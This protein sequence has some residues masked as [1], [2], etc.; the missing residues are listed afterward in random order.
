MFYV[1]MSQVF[2]K[3]S[4][5][6]YSSAVMDLLVCS[7]CANIFT[8]IWPCSTPRLSPSCRRLRVLPRARATI[9]NCL[10]VSWQPRKDSR[11]RRWDSRACWTSWMSVCTSAS[12]WMRI[13]PVI[14]CYR[15]WGTPEKQERRI[16]PLFSH[17]PLLSSGN[18]D[19]RLK[20][21]D[22]LSST[23]PTWINLSNWLKRV[24]HWV[25]YNKSFIRFVKKRMKHRFPRKHAAAG[26]LPFPKRS[27]IEALVHCNLLL[28]AVHQQPLV[29][30][31]HTDQH[32]QGHHIQQ[33]DHRE[34]HTHSWTWLEHV[35]EEHGANRHKA[36]ISGQWK[37]YRSGV[38]ID[39]HCNVKDRPW[40]ITT[41]ISLV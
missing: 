8:R 22:R 39:D 26:S 29:E 27:Y 34:Q 16:S 17:A 32:A 37:R 19:N 4:F 18:E 3:T 14:V 21:Q 15:S 33:H 38:G 20:L 40:E 1:V 25:L 7:A 2:V 12:L 11:R 5:V 28:A 13:T 36:V 31:G 10:S 23:T 30:Q 24:C 35:H 9:Q 6:T 41:V